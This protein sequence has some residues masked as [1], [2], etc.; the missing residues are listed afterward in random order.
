MRRDKYTEPENTCPTIDAIQKA[1]DS[2]HD[3]IEDVRNR[4]RAI[5]EWGTAWMEKAE[6]LEKE[7]E[8]SQ[9]EVERLETENDKLRAEVQRLEDER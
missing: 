6:K 7:L 2:V 1:L 4:N 8:K 3:E 9:E 5:R